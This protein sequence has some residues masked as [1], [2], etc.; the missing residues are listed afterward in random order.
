MRPSTMSD[1]NI[2]GLA[3][4]Q[5]ALDSL[6][7]KIEV[8]IMRGAIRAGCKVIALDAKQRIHNHSGELAKSIKFGARPDK[9]AGQVQGYAR[10][11]GQGKKGEK[12]A[13]YAS[14]VEYGTAAH[15]IKA[16]LPGHRLK[17]GG[18]YVDQVNHP[19]SRKFPFMR[20]AMDATAQTAVQAVADYI[21]KRLADKYGLDVPAPVDPEA[22]E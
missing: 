13:F 16:K 17:F 22:A 8:N 20:P 11:G 1:V 12:R 18:A 19:G 9:R 3:E 15:A 14:M 10:A 5:A 6:S 21:R 7:A 2:K 4:L